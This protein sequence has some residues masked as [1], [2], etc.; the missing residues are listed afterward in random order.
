MIM[1]RNP[2]VIRREL[3][4]TQAHILLIMT[5]EV[6]VTSKAG[7][8]VVAGVGIT[9]MDMDLVQP[10]MVE[11]GT[12]TINIMNEMMGGVKRVIIPLGISLVVV[13]LLAGRDRVTTEG[14]NNNCLRVKSTIPVKLKYGTLKRICS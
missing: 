10:V 14:I 9:V 3:V 2:M 6:T 8:V 13:A 5:I 11:E 4:G 1:Q 12:I 7:M